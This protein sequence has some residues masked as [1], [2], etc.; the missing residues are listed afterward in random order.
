MSNSVVRSIL[1][2][3][4]QL[5]DIRL[6]RCHRITDSAFDFT[7]SPFQFLFGCLSLEAISLQ[8][9]PQVTGDIIHTL[10]KHCRHLNY[11]NLSQCKNVKSPKIQE[12][13]QHNQ[14]K[15]LN[16]AFIDDISDEAFLLLPSNISIY[17][18]NNNNENNNQVV[19][20]NNNSYSPL[21]KLNLCKSK[22]TDMSIFR[23]AH[24]VSLLEIRLQFCTGITDTGILALVRNCPK[25]TLIDLKSCT[26]TD[27]SIICIA[28]SCK[29]LKELDLSWCPGFTDLGLFQ[30]GITRSLITNRYSSSSPN[31]SSTSTSTSYPPINI[32]QPHSNSNSYSNSYNNSYNN[33][34]YNPSQYNNGLEKLNLEWCSQITDYAMNALSMVTSLKCIKIAGCIGI[35]EIGIKTLQKNDITVES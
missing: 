2:G 22:I 4:H 17:N 5:E 6:N 12:I 19:L 15:S 3:C 32:H 20:N 21:L 16:L 10:T 24:L 35:T 29:A 7:E 25:L 34:A 9:C 28:A 31:S 33:I 11:L 23:M 13:F 1:S 30:F 14:L 27:E 8:G 26:V 18:N